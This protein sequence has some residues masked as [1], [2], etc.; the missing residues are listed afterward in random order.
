MANKIRLNDNQEYNAVWCGVA[1]GVLNIELAEPISMIETAHIFTDMA[2][3]RSIV[4]LISG[5]AA[6]VF[7]DYTTLLSIRRDRWNGRVQ[8]Q[9]EK[10]AVTGMIEEITTDMLEKKGE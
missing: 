7:A 2:R 10:A 8:I 1:D 9:L 6:A 4:Y 3:T 5:S